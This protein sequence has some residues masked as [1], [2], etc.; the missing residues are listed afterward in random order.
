MSYANLAT[1]NSFQGLQTPHQEPRALDS[2]PE[3]M[4]TLAHS[5]SSVHLNPA[6]HYTY[7]IGFEP[8]PFSRYQAMDPAE[9]P[10]AHMAYQMQHHRGF[11]SSNP[12]FVD[13]VAPAT[14][15]ATDFDQTAIVSS[16]GQAFVPPQYGSF[17]QP[18]YM[19]PNYEDP[20]EPYTSFG[21][22]EY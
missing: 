6:P 13:M 8:A 17:A 19:V 1:Y 12:S 3:E 2:G 11:D 21:R 16:A 4:V 10:Q 15:I 9:L 22:P 18:M 20:D 5:N 14:N 7:P